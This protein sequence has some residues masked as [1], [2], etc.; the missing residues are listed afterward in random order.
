MQGKVNY[1]LKFNYYEKFSY[2][3]AKH[4][5]I[6]IMKTLVKPEFIKSQLAKYTQISISDQEKVKINF[7]TKSD[8]FKKSGS[9]PK[10]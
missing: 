9:N 4:S 8:I 5:D 6:I 10:S 1:K 7:M 2:F 3:N